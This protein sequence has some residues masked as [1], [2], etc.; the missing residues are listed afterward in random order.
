MTPVTSHT[1]AYIQDVI[2]YFCGLL[3]EERAQYDVH[4]TALSEIEWNG[5]LLHKIYRV[6][7]AGDRV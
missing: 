3:H 7:P 5:V 1:R 4:M 6:S 2:A